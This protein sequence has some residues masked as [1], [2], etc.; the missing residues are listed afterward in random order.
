M[1][2]YSPGPLKIKQ[3]RSSSEMSLQITSMADIFVILLVFLLKSYASSST[4]IV[5]GAH[6][7]LPAAHTDGTP[8]DA[9]KIEISAAGVL[10]D[11]EPVMQ[12]NNFVLSPKDLQPNGAAA[13]V[14]AA[15]KIKKK[16]QE[17]IA[18]SNSDVKADHKIL[19]VSDQDTPYGTLKSILAAAGYEG[20]DDY[21]LVVMKK[22]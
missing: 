22:E 2:H 1:D 17:L 8:A 21:Q 18:Q 20:F 19:I 16:R 13:P 4:N 9:A 15:L 14:A 6:L 10:I 3:R 12:L 11:S 5:P 7:H